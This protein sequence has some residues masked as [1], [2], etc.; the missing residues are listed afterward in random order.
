MTIEIVQGREYTLLPGARRFGRNREDAFRRGVTRVRAI[1]VGVDFD[2][3]AYV[4]SLDGPEGWEGNQRG[5]N[6]TGY[7][8]PEFL[9]ELDAV[10]A[11]PAPSRELKAGD[12]VRYTGRGRWAS[13]TNRV[14]KLGR[15]TSLSDDTHARVTWDDGDTICSRPWLDN[16][17]LV[18]D[19]TD[20]PKTV[21]VEDAF[22]IGNTIQFTV[23]AD[24]LDNRLEVGCKS[25]RMSD[26]VE[27]IVSMDK[28]AKT[29]TLEAEVTA[30]AYGNAIIQKHGVTILEHEAVTYFRDVKIVKEAAPVAPPR[31]DVTVT[32]TPDEADA[33]A[34]VTGRMVDYNGPTGTAYRKLDAAGA[35]P[36]NYVVTDDGKRIN[37]RS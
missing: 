31:A 4:E 3:D 15:I 12:R 8:L 23:S 29:V 9:Q 7:V 24:R 1:A 34:A 2:G 30:S 25:A 27:S 33:L 32:L 17:E 11:A 35:K 37:K 5:R 36:E 6:T 28:T 20:A 10:P 13:S 19:T 26:A 18:T 16:L 14:G 21:S 22:K